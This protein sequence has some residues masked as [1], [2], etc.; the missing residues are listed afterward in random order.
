M[1]EQLNI[2]TIIK[3]MTLLS[4]VKIFLRNMTLKNYPVKK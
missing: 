3:L 2:Q 4:L 1:I